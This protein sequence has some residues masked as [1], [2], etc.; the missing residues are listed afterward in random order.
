[1]QTVTV[2]GP[3]GIASTAP[4]PAVRLVTV[5]VVHARSRSGE[6]EC[7]WALDQAGKPH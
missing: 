2:Q 6:F 3:S 4:E 7:E 1:M 5:K